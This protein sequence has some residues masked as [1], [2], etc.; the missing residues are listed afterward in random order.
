MASPIRSEEYYAAA[1][2]ASG[3]LNAYN[4]AK[5][6]DEDFKTSCLEKA[7]VFQKEAARLE[8]LY[9]HALPPCR[10]CGRKVVSPCHD[11]EGYHEGGPW[12]DSCQDQF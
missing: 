8:S 10:K 6:Y 1:R 3:W 12:D 2:Q 7:L 5:F 9:V 4:K 11:S